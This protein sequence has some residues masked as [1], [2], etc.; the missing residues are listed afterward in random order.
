VVTALVAIEALT[1]ELPVNL[2]AVTALLAILEVVIVPSESEVESET[3]PD[4]LKE[5]ADAVTSPV[6]AKFLA[7]DNTP[8]EDTVPVTF[9]IKVPATKV[10]FPTVHLLALSSQN[11]VLLV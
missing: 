2:A 10:S 5:T 6:S 9:P 4:P 11:N 7:V 8:A 3:S 1:T